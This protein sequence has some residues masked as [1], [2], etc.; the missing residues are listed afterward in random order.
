VFVYL[1]CL[2]DGVV[3]G[4]C[5]FICCL[6]WESRVIRQSGGEGEV[7]GLN[8]GP[9]EHP[10]VLYYFFFSLIERTNE[11]TN[12]RKNRESIVHWLYVYSIFQYFFFRFFYVGRFC[13]SAVPMFLF[14]FAS[15]FF[16]LVLSN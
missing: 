12:E 7:Y 1:F 6:G 4:V 16:F 15:I 9:L 3:V 14:L 11:R 2:F 13:R 10:L 5:L 8:P